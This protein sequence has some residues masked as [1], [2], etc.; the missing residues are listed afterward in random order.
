MTTSR[1][2]P[3]AGTVRLTRRLYDAIEEHHKNN[4]Q[5]L[6]LGHYKSFPDGTQD[7]LWVTRLRPYLKH[8]LRL[9]LSVVRRGDIF[10]WTD[11]EVG[12][13]ILKMNKLI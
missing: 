13:K 1:H 10:D 12:T 6:V 2:I 8:Q 5:M 3:S 9:H 7:R 11:K 4:L